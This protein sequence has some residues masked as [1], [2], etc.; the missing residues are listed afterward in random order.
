MTFM[1]RTNARAESVHSEML[2]S[3]R[4]EFIGLISI[5]IS[6]TSLYMVFGQEDAPVAPPEFA[7]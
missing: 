1:S 6:Y 2:T 4:R 5:P 3:R 7:T